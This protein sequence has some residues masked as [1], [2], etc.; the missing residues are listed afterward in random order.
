MIQ[1]RS[2]VFETN[3]SSTHSLTMCTQ[4]EF[5]K[6]KRG[7][8]WFDIDYERLIKREIAIEL[9][10]EASKAYYIS[11]HPNGCFYKTWEELSEEQIEQWHKN[12]LD[13]QR[14]K[15]EGSYEYQT[16]DQWCR[17]YDLEKFEQHYTSPSGDK[18]VAFGKFGYN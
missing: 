1:I 18:I 15:A 2:G 7:E 8:M 5:D 10:E 4:E 11:T 16:Y 3:S 17:E 6:W 12:Y 14:R 9:D 13:A